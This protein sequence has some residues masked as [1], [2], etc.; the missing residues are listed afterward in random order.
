MAIRIGADQRVAVL[1]KKFAPARPADRPAFYAAQML[2]QISFEVGEQMLPLVRALAGQ[3][4]EL[5]NEVAVVAD[6]NTQTEACGG[7]VADHDHHRLHLM[8][9]QL[10]QELLNRPRRALGDVGQ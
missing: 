8:P 2:A 1:F 6:Y 7:T 10:A 3:P 9:E 5:G 4:Y